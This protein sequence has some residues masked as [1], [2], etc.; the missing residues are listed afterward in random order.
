[1]NSEHL[2]E[3]EIQQYALD[4][5]KCD[6]Y[7]QQHVASCERCGAQVN[8]YAALYA[9]LQEV[10]KPSFEFDVAALIQ[11]QIQPKPKA[12]R[13]YPMYLLALV[14]IGLVSL[15]LYL[16]RHYILQIFAGFSFIL[17]LLLV[18]TALAI[19]IFQGVDIYRKYQQ[20]INE[21]NFY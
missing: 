15:L 5:T 3:E 18:I 16:L 6:V 8:T 12:V 19:V 11:S 17:V 21:L 1:M 4:K 13:P 2:T 20:K 10:E 9:G 7:M 14:G